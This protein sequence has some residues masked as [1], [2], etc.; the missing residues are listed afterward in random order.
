MQ[1]NS[2]RSVLCS[3]LLFGIGAEARRLGQPDTTRCLRGLANDEM[4]VHNCSP[5]AQKC[6]TNEVLV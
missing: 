4:D 1:L 5:V 2:L 6:V 3:S